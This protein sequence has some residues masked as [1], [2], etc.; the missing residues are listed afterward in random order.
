M[1]IN[2]QYTMYKLAYH[3]IT[4]LEYDVLY[5]S[6]QEH[7]IWLEQ[8]EGSKSTVIRFTTKGFDWKNHLKKDIALV[9]QKVKAMKKLLQA[10]TINIHNIYIS[11]HTPVDDWEILKKPMQL[12]E[13]KPTMMNVYYL[14]KRNSESS[15]DDEMDRI[16]KAIEMDLPAIELEDTSLDE[17]EKEEQL[18]YY[19]T[20]VKQ[21]VVNFKEQAQAVFSFGKPR[22]TYIL[23]VICI[24]LFLWMEV[25]G[26]SDNTNTLI[27]FGAKYN[28]AMIE[29]GQWWR[30]ISSMFLHIGFLHL[31]MNM[32]AVYYLG[33]LVERI[34]GSWRFLVI[35]FLAGIGGG[36][37]SFAFSPSIAAGASGALF[38][39][40]GALLFFGLHNRRIF[41]QTMGTNVLILIGINVVF[42]LVVPQIDNGAH[43]G[44]LVAGFIASAIVHL[45]KHRERFKQ[46]AACIVY[47]ILIFSII[48]YGFSNNLNDQ[49]YHVMQMERLIG[50]E[51][52]H[53]VV[54]QGDQ[55]LN[56]EGDLD[57]AILFHRSYA[58]IQLN[59]PQEAIEDLEKSIELD[60]S[61]PQAFHNLAIL[62]DS[63]GERNKAEAIIKK[64][65][66][67]H[68]DDPDIKSLYE[69]IIGNAP[70]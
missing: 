54:S 41:F 25:S 49:V 62:Y 17:Q 58:Y 45:P 67:K 20:Y 36:I 55:A 34:F 6:E 69:Q 53:T 68:P 64:G 39:L 2:E 18:S 52:Y 29:D 48:Q 32:I 50:Q 40:F 51:D 5:V 3:F 35:Y 7:E 63:R 10:K 23:L 28:P 46:L 47:I 26:G 30:I 56:S 19:K 43:L 42:G 21:R 59:Q 37:A 14:S 22:F 66:Q 31:A 33:A 70:N 1:Y 8:H 13:K 11:E 15:Y 65:Y 16:T 38:G 27:E 61:L 4:K 57:A 60:T 44:G 24:S 12:N 9:F